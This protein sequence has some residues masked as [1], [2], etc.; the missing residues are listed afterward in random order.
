VATFFWA[1]VQYTRNPDGFLPFLIEVLLSSHQ[2]TCVVGIACAHP[3]P[4]TR[5]VF[6]RLRSVVLNTAVLQSRTAG[7]AEWAGELPQ[8]AD[9]VG[10]IH[11]KWFLCV[12]L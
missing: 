6:V 1:A 3:G 10:P 11:T 5:D 2:L 9:K 7:A 4:L 12:S 8:E